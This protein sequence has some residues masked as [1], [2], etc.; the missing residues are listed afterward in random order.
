MNILVNEVAGRWQ[1][2]RNGETHH[3]EGDASGYRCGISIRGFTTGKRG[4]QSHDLQE[5][6]FGRQ[7]RQEPRINNTK[8]LYFM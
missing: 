3:L 2:I 1:R 6:H 5:T 7:P 8:Y 4:G